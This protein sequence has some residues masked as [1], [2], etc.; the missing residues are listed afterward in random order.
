LVKARGIIHLKSTYS[1]LPQANLTRVVV[2]E[3]KIESSRCGPFEAAIRLLERGIIDVESLIEAH[4]P[5]TEAMRAFEHAAQRG[6][7]KVVLDIT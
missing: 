7:L 3:V 4:Y 5:I 6:V 1:A 2:D